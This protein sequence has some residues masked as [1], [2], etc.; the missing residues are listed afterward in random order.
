MPFRLRDKIILITFGVLFCVAVL[1]ISIRLGGFV[2]LSLQEYRNLLSIRHKGSYRIMCLGE[3]TTAMGEKPYPSQ[4]EEILN[5]SNIGIKFSVINKGLVAADTSTIISQLEHNLDKYHPDLVVAMMG[6]N[7][8]FKYY[9]DIPEAKT[10]FFNNFKVYKLAR[11][12]CVNVIKKIRERESLKAKQA[13]QRRENEY[14][15]LSWKYLN[16]QNFSQAE[17]SFKKALESNTED[18]KLYVGLGKSYINQR[19]L[20]L[21]ENA[22][23]KALEL[24]PRSYDVYIELGAY[25]RVQGDYYSVYTM[26]KK[27]IELNPKNETAYLELGRSYRDKGRH[28]ESEEMYRRAIDLNPKNAES[29]CELGLSYMYQKKYPQ[30]E[31]AFKKV[32]DINPKKDKAYGGL[33]ILYREIGKYNLTEE[34]YQKSNKIRLEYCNSMTTRNYRE[35]KNILD[36]RKIKLV[37]M[38][39]PVRSIVP[40]KNIFS[41]DEGK[42]IIFVD[43][44]K[45]FKEA[46]R[47]TSYSVY[48]QDVFAGDFG[49]C[50]AKGNRLIAENILRAM[51]SEI[52]G[53]RDNGFKRVYI[54]NL[55]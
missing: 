49:H 31:E 44:E 15:I 19:K 16:Q 8:D 9:E 24:N 29:Y 14:E 6:I 55:N 21:A 2:F 53:K 34:Y 5:Q 35:L 43:N 25:Y 39:Y 11:I 45:T 51:L 38:Q 48:F 32:V 50:T 22:F 17:Y 3:S 36:K 52:F 23:K 20:D 13:I 18:D 42:T 30:A 28:A 10:F 27:A 1:E 33:A 4:L 12:L 37:C 54:L 26:Y 40:L 47:K 41:P 7:D 46:L